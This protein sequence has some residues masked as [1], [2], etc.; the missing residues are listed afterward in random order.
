M[1]RIS[2]AT[3]PF[4]KELIQADIKQ[5]SKFQFYHNEQCYDSPY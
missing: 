3:I 4:S 1:Y 2:P 5:T